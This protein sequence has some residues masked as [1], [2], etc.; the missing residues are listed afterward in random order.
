M[1]WF[2]DGLDWIGS[3]FGSSGTSAQDGTPGSWGGSSSS[4]G[5]TW[6]DRNWGTISKGID[7]GRKLYNLYDAN[8]A[9]QGVRSDIMDVYAKMEAED[10]AYQQQLQ[11]YQQQQSAGAAA[12]RRQ[13][14]AARRKA[15][16]KALKFQKKAMGELIAQYQPYNDSIKALVPKMTENYSQ[17]LDTTGLL[18][19]YLAPAVKKNMDQPFQ[20]AYTQNVPSANFN[21]PVPQGQPVSFPTLDEIL[22]KGK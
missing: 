9:Q 17:F 22:K 12:A 11:A 6:L 18:N 4:T 15:E 2:S 16:A 20:S 8:S 14:D 21:I 13:T 7:A 10:K 1:S 3:Q 5:G 19:Q